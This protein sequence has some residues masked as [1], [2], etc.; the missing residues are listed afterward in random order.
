VTTSVR[1]WPTEPSRA[2]EDGLAVRDVTYPV[3]WSSLPATP[4][5]K[6]AAPGPQ[7]GP[8]RRLAASTA[9][10]LVL[11][12]SSY[13]HLSQMADAVGALIGKVGVAFSSPRHPARRPRSD[14]VLDHNVPVALQNGDRCLDYRFPG[15]QAVDQATVRRLM[16]DK[17]G[18][19]VKKL[20]QLREK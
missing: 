12:Y 8:S 2:D 20:Q 18:I 4:F 14:L 10:I 11:Y 9:A 7:P 5:E 17:L 1:V 6:T 13:R 15:Q 16:Q 19:T 3:R